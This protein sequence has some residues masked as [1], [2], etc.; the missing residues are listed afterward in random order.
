MPS[1]WMY[2]KHNVHTRRYVYTL[3]ERKTVER[4]GSLLSTAAV[5]IHRPGRK[6]QTA[7]EVLTGTT[8]AMFNSSINVI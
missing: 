6:Q 7:G 5:Y 1:Y 4:F 2:D 3:K 8:A